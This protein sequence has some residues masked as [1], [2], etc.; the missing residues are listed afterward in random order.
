VFSRC[1]RS[2][3]KQRQPAGRAGT[4]AFVYAERRRSSLASMNSAKLSC[5]LIASA[6]V[7]FRIS[8]LSG[9]PPIADISGQCR[10][11]RVVPKPTFP[12]SALRRALGDDV[13]DLKRHHYFAGLIDYL[14]ERGDRAA[15]GL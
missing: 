6:L 12:L 5:R 2:E 1:Q 14:D 9:L 13:D 8:L 10:H 4:G 3:R 11:F 15:I 7:R